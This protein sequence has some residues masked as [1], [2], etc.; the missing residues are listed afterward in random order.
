[1][2]TSEKP[3]KE[4]YVTL[5]SIVSVVRHLP[6]WPA[7]SLGP[8]LF[9]SPFRSSTEQAVGRFPSL[10]CALS[11][12][13]RC[14]SCVLLSSREKFL[15]FSQKKVPRCVKLLL[16]LARAPLRDFSLLTL[17]LLRSVA[18]WLNR[19]LCAIDG[20]VRTRFLVSTLNRMCE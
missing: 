16:L 5:N 11:T 1:M 17:I 7:L 9:F 20:A 4:G 19:P 18:L 14:R 6:P 2:K 3:K 10:T 8:L 15:T 13:S 12:V